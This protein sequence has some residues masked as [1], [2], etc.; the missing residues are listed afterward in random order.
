MQ[1]MNAQ[2]NG[3]SVGTSC[4]G[5]YQQGLLCF[6]QSQGQLRKRCHEQLSSLLEWDKFVPHEGDV[7]PVR[8]VR[9]DFRACLESAMPLALVSD[10]IGRSPSWPHVACA[11]MENGNFMWEDI[12]SFYAQEFMLS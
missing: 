7:G 8:L 1:S 11:A 6:H 5:M 12:N 4:V 9:G 3:R 10:V 2:G